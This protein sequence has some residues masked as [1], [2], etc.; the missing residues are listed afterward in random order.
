MK[1]LMEQARENGEGTGCFINDLNS[2]DCRKGCDICPLI[3][4]VGK[5]IH[6]FPTIEMG[7]GMK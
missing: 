1:L 2:L 4:L 3:A 5:L 7:P 6:G